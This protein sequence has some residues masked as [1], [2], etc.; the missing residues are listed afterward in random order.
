MG[1]LSAS[2]IESDAVKRRASGPIRRLTSSPTREAQEV[3]ERALFYDS[4]NPDIY[5]NLGVVFLEQGKALQALAYLDK[6]L[7]FDPDHTQALM[8]SAILIQE[9][10]IAHLRT[11][12]AARLMKLLAKDERNERVFFNLGML[13]MDDGDVASAEAWFRKA[14]DVREDF[15]SA[16]FNLALLLSEARRPLEAVPFLNQLLKH[17]GDHIK[18]LILLG[19]IYINHMKDL[20]AAE[21]LGRHGFWDETGRRLLSIETGAA[22]GNTATMFRRPV[23]CAASD[24]A[25]P[26][27]LRVEECAEWASLIKTQKPYF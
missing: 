14:V 24:E 18:G 20:D 12:A 22:W 21:K 8:N 11:T 7:E 6:A 2:C 25:R 16:L 1:D 9:S 5:Y 26:G 3:Y 4:N 27:R 10:G 13:A 23:L 15:R 19:D 17:H